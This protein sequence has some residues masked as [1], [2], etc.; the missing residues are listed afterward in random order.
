ML[1]GLIIID[2]ESNTAGG[3]CAQKEMLTSGRF[4]MSSPTLAPF[5][6]PISIKELARVSVFS[7]NA[8]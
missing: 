6:N 3:G 8:S 7:S 5:F 1:Q 4:G 2:G